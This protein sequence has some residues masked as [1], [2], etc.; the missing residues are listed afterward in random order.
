MSKFKRKKG[1]YTIPCSS[2]FK[3][4]VIQL[5]NSHS[6]NV[7]D[8]A[9][10][11][12]FLVPSFILK[13]LPDPGEPNRNDREPVSIQSGKKIGKTWHRK[14]RLQIRLQARFSPSIVRR[15][16]KLALDLHNNEA[17]LNVSDKP[18]QKPELNSGNAL[19]FSEVRAL[20]KT[21]GFKPLDRDIAT[22]EDALHILGFAPRETVNKS[23][24]EQRFRQLATI[25]H[26]DSG[27]GS[28]FHMS[29]LNAS[30]EILRKLS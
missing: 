5:A 20:V 15:A 19:P 11:I 9:R 4:A 3:A 2:N 25:Y 7:G 16:L 17:F 22:I 8:V 18:K 10:S 26:P 14:P 1:S 13:E 6:V 29:Q 28:H 12:L 21:L 24:A 23:S 30:I 27:Y